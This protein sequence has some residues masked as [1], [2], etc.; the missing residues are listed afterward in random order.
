MHTYLELFV[1][2]VFK[3]AVPWASQVNHPQ[4]QSGGS[5][6]KPELCQ[7]ALN[8]TVLDRMWLCGSS[9]DF[10][11]AQTQLRV[12]ASSNLL[13]NSFTVFLNSFTA[14]TQHL[15]RMG[16]GAW[17]PISGRISLLCIQLCPGHE[18]SSTWL[19]TEF[20]ERE[21]KQSSGLPPHLC[22][23]SL[24]Q[25]NKVLKPWGPASEPTVVLTALLSGSDWWRR[26]GRAG[27]LWSEKWDQH[28]FWL[29][30]LDRWLA[31][32]TSMTLIAKSL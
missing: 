27:P 16:R 1:S 32:G 4:G 31:L 11:A 5:H 14:M 29:W 13:L 15:L 10:R 30:D 3:T 9:T 21:G 24:M 8:P 26:R 18:G 6:C 22:S 2:I 28:H 25:T 19:K 20:S 17:S 7:A 23:G 12:P